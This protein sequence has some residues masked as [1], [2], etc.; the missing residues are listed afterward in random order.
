MFDWRHIIKDASVETADV[1]WVKVGTKAKGA[2]QGVTVNIY[3][4]FTDNI[5][6]RFEHIQFVINIYKFICA[7]FDNDQNKKKCKIN[8][9]ENYETFCVQIGLFFTTV[10]M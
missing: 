10:Y 6:Q 7:W 3:S 2:L 5:T 1:T 4:Y 9:T 8:Y